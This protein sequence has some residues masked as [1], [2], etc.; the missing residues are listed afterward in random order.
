MS[1]VHDDYVDGDVNTID[2]N[3]NDVGADGYS[4]AGAQ[5]VT[6]KA[7]QHN[8]ALSLIS[9]RFDALTGIDTTTVTAQ[10]S[11]VDN[12]LTASYKATSELL[13]L[14]LVSYLK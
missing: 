5:A 13:S 12:Q 8:D 14:S 4:D 10:L 2:D 1:D 3:D 11:A 9:T 7:T 6:A